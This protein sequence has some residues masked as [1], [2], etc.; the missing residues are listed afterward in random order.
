MP[1][2]VNTNVSSLNAQRQLISSGNSL[3]Q[4]FERLSSGFRINSAADDAAGLQISNRLGSQIDGLNQGNRN[5]NDGI[6]LAQT[7]EGAL[8]EITNTFQRV[9]TLAQ[10]A[11]NGS[12]TD[13]DRVAIQE[14]IDALMTEVNRIASDTTFG[15]QNLLDGTYEANFQV[16]ADA[17]QT[18]GITMTQVGGTAAGND[19]SANGGF[20]L[21]G[22]AGA[23]STVTGDQVSTIV[24]SVYAADADNATFAGMFAS[25]NI[26]VTSEANAQ[27]VLAGMDSMIAVVDKKRAELGATQ[28][29]FQSTI[30]NQGNV[31]ENLSEAKSR[32]KDA[33]FAAETAKLTQAQILQQA[34]QTILA[35]ANQRPQ[36]A[37]QL[38]G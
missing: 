31:S 4:A 9:R 5:A 34:S 20:T 24:G 16:G 25:G 37:L 19:I 23:A 8:D 17:N 32:I 28:N 10:Q 6:S 13:E 1:L 33:D 21:S 12:N 30:R 26:S 22:I 36:A 15:G 7:A 27:V 14:E 18:I 38:L 3:D 29:R 35:Q 11:S 2:Y